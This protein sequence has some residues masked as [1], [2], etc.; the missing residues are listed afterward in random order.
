MGWLSFVPFRHIYTLSLILIGVGLPLSR[1]FMSIGVISLGLCWLLEAG[2]K[3]K[4][5]NL[6]G[7]PL[8][9]VLISLYAIHLLGLLY[10]SDYEYALTDLRI[11]LPLFVLPVVLGTIP[12]LQDRA[13]KLVFLTFVLAVLV[14]AGIILNNYMDSAGVLVGRDLVPFVSH[15]R[16]ALLVCLSIA[17][18]LY[19]F[20]KLGKIWKVTF[21]LTTIFLIYVL[22]IIQSGTGFIV[23]TAMLLLVM[24]HGSNRIRSRPLR[25]SFIAGISTCI[26]LPLLLIGNSLTNHYSPK[27]DISDL[28]YRTARGG[29]YSH[30]LDNDQLENGY[31]V[32]KYIAWE[33]LEKAWSERSNRDFNGKDAN[34][35][36]LYGTLIRYITSKGMRKDADAVDALTDEEIHHIESGVSSALQ[37]ERSPIVQRLHE[38]IFEFDVYLTGDDPSGHSVTQR[39]EFWKTGTRIFKN[40]WLIG[41]GTG[42]VQKAFDDQYEMDQSILRPEARLRAHNQY[43]TFFVTFG[44]LGGGLFLLVLLLPF[45]RTSTDFLYLC[46]FLIISM[47]FLWEDTLETQAGVTL[48]AFF[49]CVLLFARTGTNRRVSQ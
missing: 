18:M 13:L 21:G 2:F 1:A 38:I 28:Q 43:I 37:L 33:E 12:V 9:L 19:Y 25:W 8:I 41:V 6:I 14:N 15:V 7:Q 3:T 16:Y 23:L 46:F 45:L 4:L 39:L 48:Y 44:V 10:T 29:V 5:K 31:Y 32:W 30:D 42:D 34:G 49:N 11:K 26:L 17:I 47:S 36:P 27:E 24:Y 35:Q 20:R 40:H 22:A